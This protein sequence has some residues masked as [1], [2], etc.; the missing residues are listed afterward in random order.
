MLEFNIVSKTPNK[1][2]IDEIRAE[3][4]GE[5][6]NKYRQIKLKYN[7]YKLLKNSGSK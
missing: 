6:V 3:N 2:V 5:F 7:V 4:F 1:Y